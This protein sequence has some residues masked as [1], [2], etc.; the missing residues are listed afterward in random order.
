MAE[1]L[2]EAQRVGSSKLPWGTTWGRSL[3]G[4][5]AVSKTARWVF[6]SPRPCH[7]HLLP[8]TN[9]CVTGLSHR[10]SWVRFPPAVPCVRSSSG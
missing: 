10:G 1:Q 4:K 7:F 9:G 5:T 2:V 6:E 8:K 3:I